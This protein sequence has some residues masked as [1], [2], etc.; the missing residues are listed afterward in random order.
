MHHENL[1]M[2]TWSSAVSHINWY[3]NISD[4]FD[5]LPALSYSIHKVCVWSVNYVQ[6]SKCHPESP[7]PSESTEYVVPGSSGFHKWFYECIKILPLE[8]F[9]IEDNCCSKLKRKLQCFYRPQKVRGWGKYLL[10]SSSVLQK[11][12]W[13]IHCLGLS[14]AGRQRPPGHYTHCSDV[15]TEY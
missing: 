11:Q 3:S 6:H 4:I 5:I 13:H 10:Q 12:D 14:P 7:W 8:S 1:I 15:H 2:T 9:V